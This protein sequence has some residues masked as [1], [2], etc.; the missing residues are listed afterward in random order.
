MDRLLEKNKI[1]KQFQKSHKLNVSIRPNIQT[2]HRLNNEPP[3]DALRHPNGLINP[4]FNA[5][6]SPIDI[7][8]K[9]TINVKTNKRNNKTKDRE[10][11]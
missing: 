7:L 4:T 9:K 11:E 10:S 6:K 1:F 5:I 8:K 2:K 3:L